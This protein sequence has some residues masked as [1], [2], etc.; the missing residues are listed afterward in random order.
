[1]LKVVQE[2]SRSNVAGSDLDETVPNGAR[3]MLR[4]ALRA[5]VAYSDAYRPIKQIDSAQPRSRPVNAPHLVLL[6]GAGAT[7]VNG[8]LLRRPA[9]DGQHGDGQHGDGQQAA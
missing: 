5:E 8:K 4:V 7:L 1:M 2:R 9:D 6:V 3:L